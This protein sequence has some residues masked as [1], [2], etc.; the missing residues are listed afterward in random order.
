MNITKTD[1]AA[2]SK[3]PG[4]AGRLLRANGD[5]AGEAAPP[6]LTPP[7]TPPPAP[8]RAAAATPEARSAMRCASACCGD[9]SQPDRAAGEEGL[10]GDAI[11]IREWYRRGVRKTLFSAPFR[12]NK[13]GG[14]N[15][16]AV[17]V[18]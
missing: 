9:S 10:R 1:E 13:L 6:P 17:E 5:A 8:R 15:P 14:H 16:T 12:L 4:R 11:Q 2:I 3:L 18:E 7:L